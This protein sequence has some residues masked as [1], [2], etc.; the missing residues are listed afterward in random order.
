MA[1]TLQTL[2]ALP[3]FQFR[4]FPASSGEGNVTKRH[5][6]TCQER[7]PADCLE[8]Q[9][10]KVADG[11]L[12]GRY[13]VPRGQAFSLASPTIDSLPDPKSTNPLA[14]DSSTPVFQEGIRP[15]TFKALI[16]K[17][18]EEFGTMRQ[19]DSEEF[20]GHLVE[21]IRR[22][23]KRTSGSDENDPTSIFKFGLEQR[24][25]CGN[26]GRV[27]YRVEK[28]D[29]LSVSVPRRELMDVD[30]DGQAEGKEE[31]KKFEEVELKECLD[32][33]TRVEALEYTCSACKKPVIAKK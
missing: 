20:F 8:C 25:E 21:S 12:S 30:K 13:S 9:L 14:H 33:L 19:Q 17:G 26:C 29:V 7:L 10:Y 3:S 32:G 27:R 28:A 15:S 11:L 6:L 16:G 2:F 5:W 4:Y 18:H 1:S 24:L 22:Y 31:A 23:I